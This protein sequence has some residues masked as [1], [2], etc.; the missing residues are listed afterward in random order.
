MYARLVSRSFVASLLLSC[1]LATTAQAQA[2]VP[3][4]PVP[5]A[6]AAVVTEPVAPPPVEP[7]AVA[8]SVTVEAPKPLILG[9][10]NT[11]EPRS[12]GRVV[13]GAVIGGSV[14]AATSHRPD[15]RA[16]G[17]GF[18]F[19]FSVQVGLS[20]PTFPGRFGG[21][22][23][24]LEAR[25][26]GGI[27]L[28]GLFYPDTYGGLVYGAAYGVVGYEFL[29][30]RAAVPNERQ[31]GIGAFAGFR[32]GFQYSEVLNSVTLDSRMAAGADATVGFSLALVVPKYD[33]QKR[34]LH[35]ALVGVDW[36][37]VPAT[38][39]NLMTLSAAVGF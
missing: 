1:L 29:H 15:Y 22:W 7:P 23:H 34:H 32:C 21:N 36:W 35:R 27:G 28:S 25:A 17:L 33:L 18:D 19:G 5:T 10:V 12:L 8:T 13:L 31:R 6:P 24:G 11:A 30:F 4:E 9:E 37:T 2:I 38:N 39:I 26:M 14:L 3:Q 16:V 20:S